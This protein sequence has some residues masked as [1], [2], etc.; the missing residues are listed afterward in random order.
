MKAVKVAVLAEPGNVLAAPR[1]ASAAPRGVSA[2]PCGV[3][4]TLR[5]DVVNE[6]K[7]LGTIITNDLKWNKN[8]KK[9]TKC[10]CKNENV[11]YSCKICEKQR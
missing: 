2:A 3:S 7:L 5:L 8:T 6:V 4:A 10:K 1:G 11:A 9:G